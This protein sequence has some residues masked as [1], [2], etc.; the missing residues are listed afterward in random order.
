MGAPTHKADPS[1]FLAC[2]PNTRAPVSSG[3]PTNLGVR[4]AVASP[5]HLGSE[6]PH[7]CCHGLPGDSPHPSCGRGGFI[8]SFCRCLAGLQALPEPLKPQRPA[9]VGGLGALSSADSGS[10]CGSRP[11]RSLGIRQSWVQGP[12]YLLRGI[13]VPEAGLGSV[14]VAVSKIGPALLGLTF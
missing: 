5:H 11:R 4:S 10:R 12:V 8:I 7:P 3:M 6:Q 13:C 9:G 14:G 1:P 2:T